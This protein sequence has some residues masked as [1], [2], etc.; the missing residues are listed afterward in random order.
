MPARRGGPID[1]DDPALAAMRAEQSAVVPAE[2]HSS[3]PAALALPMM[4]QASLAG[5]ALLGQKPTGEDYRPDEIEVLG[6]AVQQIGLD[7]QAIRVRDLEL[8]NVRLAERNQT[9]T[10]LL[11]AR[12][13]PA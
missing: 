2:V 1:A 9:L 12:Q 3:L 11:A 5:F 13:A 10:E 4:H 7:L 6:W 8:A